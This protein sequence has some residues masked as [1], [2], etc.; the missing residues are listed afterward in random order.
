MRSPHSL[1]Q[2]LLLV[3]AL[4]SP[5]SGGSLR[6]IWEVDLTA[7]IKGPGAHVGFQPGILAIRFSPDGKEIAIATNPYRRGRSGGVSKVITLALESARRVIQRFDIEDLAS[8]SESVAQGPPAISW[9]PTGDFVLAGLSLIRL[10]EAAICEIPNSRGHGFVAPDRIVAGVLLGL[11]SHGAARSRVELF[12]TEC[13]ST[14]MWQP[15]YQ[16]WD[17]RD[18]AAD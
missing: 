2:A 15:S 5:A 12:D 17:I 3:A 6:K 11:D 7:E 8:D 13:R 10:K 18:V 16:E 9:S 14:G 1:W 4:H